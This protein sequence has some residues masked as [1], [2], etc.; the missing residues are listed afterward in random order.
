MVNN[1]Q[2]DDLCGHYIGKYNFN[3]KNKVL[4]LIVENV[5]KI[6]S[7]LMRVAL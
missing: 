7:Y 2:V 5:G 6:S 1:Y 4:Q 3:L